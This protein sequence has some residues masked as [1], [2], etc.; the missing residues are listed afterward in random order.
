[1][2]DGASP[3]RLF[4][5]ITLPLLRPMLTIVVG[6]AL[7]NSFKVFD[8]IWVMTQGGPY[9]SSETLAVTMYRESFVSFQLGYGAAVAIVLSLIV[10]VLSIS[11]LRTMFSRDADVYD[12]HRIAS[13]RRARAAA[14]LRPMAAAG[15]HVSPGGALVGA[16]L[17]A[18]DHPDEGHAG[19]LQHLAVGAA[20]DRP[21]SS[22]TSRPPGNRRGWGPASWP[23]S[24]TGWWARAWRSS[25][26]RSAF[27]I[28]R[29]HPRPVLWFFLVFSGTIVPFQMYLIPLFQTYNNVGLYDTWLG[30][31]LFYTAIAIPFS[32]FV[33]R[34]AFST[35][36]REVLEAAR[37]DGCRDF[38]VY[39]RSACRWRAAR[40]PCCS[41]SSSPGSE[42]PDL[43]P[44][45]L[46]L[47]WRAP[48][49]AEPGRD[50]GA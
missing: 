35:I 32:L 39:W 30:M 34:G 40:S 44:G 10:M 27:A 5:H 2:L 13:P 50:A 6:I 20:Q 46:H 28:T 47:G 45:A 17:V 49:H 15:R 26:H 33:M 7:I 4:W 38:D 19:V 18:A 11:Y 29:L 12:G 25:A 48:D 3:V 22:P 1:M 16:V 23:A 31:V 8:I 21:R 24:P 43:R 36:S 42:R 9:R 14:Q 37:L 41:S